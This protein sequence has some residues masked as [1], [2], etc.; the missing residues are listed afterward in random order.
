M[1]GP[2]LSAGNQGLDPFRPFFAKWF[3]SLLSR[4]ARRL[5]QAFFATPPPHPEETGDRNEFAKKERIRSSHRFPAAM[6]GWY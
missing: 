3:L 2:D 1:H 6:A 5:I 4:D